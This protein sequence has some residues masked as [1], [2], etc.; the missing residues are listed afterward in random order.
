MPQF[1]LRG[2]GDA[3]DRRKSQVFV[4]DTATRSERPESRAFRSGMTSVSRI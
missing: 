1:Y 2:F 3:V 4:I